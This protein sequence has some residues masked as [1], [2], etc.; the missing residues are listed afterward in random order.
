[1]QSLAA[2]NARAWSVL[3]DHL[4]VDDALR[5]IGQFDTGSGNYATDRDKW[6]KGLTVE[7]IVADIER[8]RSR[9]RPKKR[10]TASVRGKK[11]S[12]SR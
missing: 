4:G 3:I 2:L 5:F 11:R 12:N 1:M 8:R 6:Q 9:T 10:A 7:G